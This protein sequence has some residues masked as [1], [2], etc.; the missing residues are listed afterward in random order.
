MSETDLWAALDE[1]PAAVIVFPD[2]QG[3]EQGRG[4]AAA[5]R[6]ARELGVELRPLWLREPVLDERADAWGTRRIVAVGEGAGRRLVCVRRAPEAWA[7]LFGG[8]AAELWED[9]TETCC[10]GGRLEAAAS[11]LNHDVRGA[12]GAAQLN[13]GA[14]LDG[15]AGE[16]HPHVRRY[17]HNAQ[18]SLTQALWLIENLVD[19]AREERLRGYLEL[20]PAALGDVLEDGLSYARGRAAEAEVELAV[21]LPAGEEKIVCDRKRVARAV[22]ALAVCAVDWAPRRGRVHAV[23]RVKGEGGK[24]WAEISFHTALPAG[25]EH[26]PDL[27]SPVLVAESPA[28]LGP[29]GRAS[30]FDF[31]RAVANAHGGRA[32]CV[33]KGQEARLTF[34]LP[35][36]GPNAQES[37]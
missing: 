2:A 7:V 15:I 30:V 29:F 24:R 35:C 18:L 14:L 17:L 5:Q 26:L 10:A 19:V 33:G 12:L 3:R 9:V 25:A 37:E 27:F 8:K 23:G 31:V 22:H 20:A 1:L 11:A 21:Q 6:L 34:L 28:E 32:L 4:N 36:E 16:L 13:I